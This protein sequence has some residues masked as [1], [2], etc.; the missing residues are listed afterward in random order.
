MLARSL[1]ILALL[2]LA[3]ARKTRRGYNV[4]ERRNDAPH[5]FVQLGRAQAE[6]NVQFRLAL[7]Q[8]NPQGLIDALY[9]V[10]IPDSP[11][12]GEH[13][14]ADE[15]CPL[16]R[17]TR[18]RLAHTVPQLSQYL[19]PKPESTKA[20]QDFLAANGLSATTLSPAGDWIGFTTNVSHANDLFSADYSVY[21]HM[22]S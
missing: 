6:K 1:L 4:H 10:S 5:G 2:G 12:Y 7:V 20:V 19:A 9:N 8:G 18:C 13:L 3:S 22:N 11:A 21:R 15:V 16:H 17:P 14:S